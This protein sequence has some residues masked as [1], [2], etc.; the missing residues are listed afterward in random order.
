MLFRSR[1]T[2]ASGP[3]G[4][5]WEC[6]SQLAPIGQS[7]L[8]KRSSESPPWIRRGAQAAP[9]RHVLAVA[10]GAS[11][12]E[13]VESRREGEVRGKRVGEELRKLTMISDSE[14][15]KAGT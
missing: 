15:S 10:P 13:G 11:G 8:R 3:P 4:Q 12:A 2:W 6:H 5:R 7:R 1:A 14:V 9:G